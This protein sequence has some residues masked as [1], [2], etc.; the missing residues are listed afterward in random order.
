MGNLAYFIKLNPNEPPPPGQSSRHGLVWTAVY[1][2]VHLVFLASSNPGLDVV[3]TVA[4]FGGLQDARPG[5]APYCRCRLR[6]PPGFRGCFGGCRRKRQT[7]IR[8]PL[9][10]ARS[11]HCVREN[12]RSARTGWPRRSPDCPI[13]HESYGSCL[14][15]SVARRGNRGVGVTLF[16]ER[17][18]ECSISMPSAKSFQSPTPWSDVKR[19]MASSRARR[20]SAVAVT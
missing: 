4:L 1:T 17:Q 8:F 15:K 5:S 20:T 18:A 9:V 14:T 6:D 7:P 10:T 3:V 11:G 2:D 19:P 16:P 13:G 12:R